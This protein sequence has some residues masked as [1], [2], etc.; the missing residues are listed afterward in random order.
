[1]RR[2]KVKVGGRWY[3]VEVGNLEGDPVQVLVDGEPVQVTLSNLGFGVPEPQA[4][5]TSN[6]AP[7]ID[8]VA[9]PGQDTDESFVRAPM[10]GVILSVGVQVGD[11][12]SVGKEVCMLEAMK[13]EQS[14]LAHRDGVV[15]AVHVQQG[16]NVTIGEVLI[17]LT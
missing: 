2:L 6:V 15:K 12:I 16:Q 8:R 7:R 3:T 14:L 4:Q 5:R 13:M 1:M 9:S 11:R 17:E 10:P